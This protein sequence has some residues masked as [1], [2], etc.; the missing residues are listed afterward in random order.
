MWF[1]ITYDRVPFGYRDIG[2]RELKNISRPIHIYELLWDPARQSEADAQP[3]SAIGE[4]TGARGRIGYIVATIAIIAAIGVIVFNTRTTPTK[5]SDLAGQRPALAVLGITD[6]TGDAGGYLGRIAHDA[7]EQ[8]FYEF[9]P[10]RLVSP[11]RVARARR[12]LGLSHDELDPATID[13]VARLAGARL[14]VS[15]RLDRRGE[16]TLQR[17]PLRP[18]GG[19]SVIEPALLVRW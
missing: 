4:G 18:R 3:P 11:L 19:R 10:V 14:A 6:Q 15:G 17:H 9:Q 5:D 13:T 8:V 16:G 7:M 1:L 12:E 2:V